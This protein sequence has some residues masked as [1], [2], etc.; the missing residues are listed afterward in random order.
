MFED[1]TTPETMDPAELRQAAEALEKFTG[2][3]Q[4]EVSYLRTGD[5]G[6]GGSTAI[7]LRTMAMVLSMR[8]IA[9]L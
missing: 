7:S 1:D 3:Y 9:S 5:E 6:G 2:D 4:S 8:M